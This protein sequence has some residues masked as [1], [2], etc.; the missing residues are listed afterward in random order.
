MTG[1]NT[2]K[3]ITGGLVA[4]VVFNVLDFAINLALADEFTANLTRLGLDPAVQN[5]PAVMATWIL[6]DFILGIIT[7]FTYAAI[8]PRFGPGPRT[9]IYAGLV[10]FTAVCAA[11]F[12][13]S[14]LGF[15][16]SA[17]LG[18]YV[19]LGLITVSLGSIAGAWT[20]REA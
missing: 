15:F 3:V 7:V 18:K 17:L 14:Q 9:A 19:A 1:I 20:Y 11:I 12:G 10:P 6:V 2:G 5:S 13:F 4:G 8:R 16:T